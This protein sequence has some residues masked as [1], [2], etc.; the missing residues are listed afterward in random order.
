VKREPE[1]TVYET[2]ALPLSYVGKQ[3]IPSERVSTRSD[4]PHHSHTQTSPAT[5][6]PADGDAPSTLTAAAGNLD[7][8]SGRRA[9]RSAA[10]LA[11]LNAALPG[12]LQEFDLRLTAGVVYLLIYRGEVVYIGQSVNLGGRISGHRVNEKKFDRVLFFTVHQSEMDRVEGTLVRYFRPRL[13]GSAPNVAAWEAAEV[14]RRLGLGK[15]ESFDWLEKCGP[16]SKRRHGASLPT[17]SNRGQ[18]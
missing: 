5:T 7:R 18:G 4:S 9:A 14:L 12:G 6:S 17:L 1:V 15:P 11:S 16:M 13:N 3:Q 2:V 8:R 10:L